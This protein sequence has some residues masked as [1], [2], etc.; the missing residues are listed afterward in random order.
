MVTLLASPLEQKIAQ[1]RVT[2]WYSQYAKIAPLEALLQCAKTEIHGS[3]LVLN[4]LVQNMFCMYRSK[5]LA[6][7]A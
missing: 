4:L 7:P 1:N 2:N 5:K 3:V 6:Q